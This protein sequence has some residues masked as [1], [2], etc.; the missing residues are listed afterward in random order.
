[1]NRFTAILCLVATPAFANTNSDIAAQEARIAALQKDLAPLIA[2]LQSS[3]SDVRVFVALDPLVAAVAGLNQLPAASRAVSLHS[4]GANGYLYSNNSMCNSFAELQGPGDLQAQGQLSAFAA[5]IQDDGSI[6]FSSHVSTSGH[7]QVH[8]Q[9][10]GPRI[11]PPWPI[12]CGGGAC[13]YGG[14]NGTS[15]GAGFNKDLDLHTRFTFALAA[16]GQSL[17]YQAALYDPQR[18]DVTISI[19][20]GALGNFGYPTS[21][22]IPQSP[23]A[24]RFAL[25]IAN[26]GQFML[27]GARDKREYDLQLKPA[28]FVSTKAGIAGEWNATLTFATAANV[29]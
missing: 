18:V 3:H 28:S 6:I 12:P 1:M 5:A 29:H 17:E 23:Q 9:F 13:P 4:T 21:F 24:G 19:G 26:K 8:V 14:G 7:I 25:L 15:V 20:L 16:D 2:P 11:C 10:F 22:T 27:P